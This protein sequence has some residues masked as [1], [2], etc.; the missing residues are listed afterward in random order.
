MAAGV[1]LPVEEVRGELLSAIGAG[2]SRIL[3]RAPTGSGKSTAVPLMLRD[4]AAVAGRIL[5]VQ[6]R[7]MAARMLATYVARLAGTR[8]GEKVGYAVRFDTRYGA[9]TEVIYLTD[10]VLQRWLQDE[11]DLPGVGAVIFDEFHERRLASDL[12]L[13]RVLDLQEGPRPDLAVLV[14]SATLDTGGLAT[15]LATARDGGNRKVTDLQ[16][17]GRTYPVEIAYR[18]EPPPRR[19]GRG[20][21]EA[22]PVWERV[23]D[24]CRDEINRIPAEPSEPSPRILVFLPGT[25]EIRKTQSLL[26]QVSWMKG[27]EVKP[28]YSAL[29]QERQWEAVAS[30]GGPRVILATNVAET[31]IT[32]EGIR[33]VIDAGLARIAEFDARRG[34]DTLTIQKVSRAAGEQRAGRAG[35][36]GPGRAV[37]LWS[38][39]E[40]ARRAPFEKP[41]VLRVDLAEA[42]LGLAAAGVGDVRHYR[43]LDAPQEQSLTRA[44]ELLRSL[45]ATDDQ[46]ITD[47]GRLL[48]RFPLHPRLSRLLHAALEED[49]VAEACFAAAVHQAG[50]CFTRKATRSQR[51]D[52]QEPDD[53]SDF[54]AEWRAAGRARQLRFDPRACQGDGIHGGQVRETLKAYEQ[55]LG[56]AKRQGMN[57]GEATFEIRREELARALLAAFSDHVAV[58]RG[59]ATLACQV[60]GGR[61]GKVA[62]G[63]MARTCEIFLATEMT[64][65]Q[66]RET[67]VHLSGCSIV[68]REW[69]EHLF[70]GELRTSD[71]A[72]F[73]E[74]TRR[75]VQCQRVTFRDLVIEEKSGG[76]AA[77][78][79][80]AAL[81]AERVVD[82]SL[83]LKKWDGKV[84]RW[85][86]RL[87]FLAEARPDLEMPAIGE[88]ER[89]LIIAQVCMGARSYKEIKDR[90]VWP[91][92][93]E[94]LSA[95]QKAALGSYAP[96]RLTLANGREVR[97][98]YEDEGPVIG[99]KVQQ[100]YGVEETPAIAG[101]PVRVEILAPNQ[102]PWQVTRDLPSFWENGYAQ[103]KKDLAGRYPK[104]EW[105]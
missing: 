16:A 71:G 8:V 44:E 41:E 7:R 77:P 92:L 91:A 103:M 75:V 72:V 17:G 81:L 80:G 57:P 12:G 2:N 90:E 45:G 31:S 98:R 101:N 66:G 24:A 49:C 74:A 102:R 13:A 46:G 48:T 70:P 43:W 54:E 19:G 99:I 15:Y 60:V 39:S 65:V 37:R 94:W 76:E 79:A 62:E 50:G 78:E 68:R 47:E 11:P 23:A 97:V 100:L 67:T 69:L 21:M 73:D 55:L 61:R 3:L 40:H 32:I 5:V 64:E 105:R 1:P 104:H 35:R 26:E 38:E 36:T 29:A 27:W 86:R 33:T 25:F 9:G 28:L 95:P 89:A 87:N 88:D 30:E 52:F 82:G 83:K 58:R 6:P 96:E 18:P 84:E 51:E 22:V 63:S 42:V 56:I 59:S 10:G 4:E 53:L 93:E 34:V 14:M 85:I 20:A